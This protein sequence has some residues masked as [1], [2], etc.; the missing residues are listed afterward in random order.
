M[1]QKLYIAGLVILAI[2]LAG[3]VFKVNH[4]AGANILLTLGI[5][6]FVLVFCP[7]ALMN[8]YRRDD[9]AKSRLLYLITGITC[10]I[11]FT[12]MLFKIMHWPYAGIALTIAIPFPYV[13]FLPVFLIVTSRDKNFNIYNVVFI[14]SLLVLNSVLNGLLAL[15]VAKSK[16]DDSM[17]I[18]ENLNNV[19]TVLLRDQNTRNEPMLQLKIDEAL[20]VIDEYQETIL[21]N[22]GLSESQWKS[23]PRGLF[24]PDSRTAARAALD[25]R[26]DLAGGVKLEKALK[27]LL[28][29]A[30]TTPGCSL[31]T[32][33]LPAIL[34]IQPENFPGKVYLT[35]DYLVWSLTYLDDL[36][37]N[38]RLIKESL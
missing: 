1:K 11:V 26:N 18:S 12:A 15:N 32:G 5:T 22:E 30:G 13:V 21:K 20:G 38:L 34:D 23:N 10:F 14:L 28:A 31:L 19:K 6:A 37:T 25:A 9:S 2:V 33:Y 29:T 3:T 8:S 7:L 16:I 4:I 35:E 36:E 27:D 24:R 17:N